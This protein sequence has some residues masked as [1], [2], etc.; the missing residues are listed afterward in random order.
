M[1][2]TQLGHISALA[3][4]GALWEGL[5]TLLLE[6]GPGPGLMPPV[7]EPGFPGPGGVGLGMRP[8]AW[9]PVSYTHLTLPTN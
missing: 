7:P 1:L 9:G 6:P 4:M 3:A 2:P 8:W 5:A